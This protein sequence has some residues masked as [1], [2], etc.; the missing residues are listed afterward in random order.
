MTPPRTLFLALLSL[1][2]GVTGCA[3]LTP[4]EQD[5]YDTFDP[6][7]IGE[8]SPNTEDGNVGGGVVTLRGSGFGDDASKVVVQFGDE[9]AEILSINDSEITVVAPTGP[10]TG[11]GV[12]VR[13]ATPSGFVNVENGYAYVIDEMYAN[14]VGYVQVNN[15]WQSC[16]G[17]LSG[18]GYRDDVGCDTF[19]YIGSTGLDGQASALTFAWPRFHSENIGFF[20]GTD[21]SIGDWRF[22]RPGATGFVFGVDELRKDIG[23]VRLVNPFYDT[24]ADVCV[25]LDSTATYRWRGGQE[26]YEAP[27]NVGGVAIPEQSNARDGACPEGTVAYASDVLRFCPTNDVEGVSDLVSR[28]D[29]P[30]AQNFFAAHRRDLKPAEVLLQAPEVGIED[31]PLTLPENLV[32]K[33]EQGFGSLFQGEAPEDYEGDLWG[34]APLLGCFDDDGDGE[35]LDDVA[36]KLTWAP[37]NAELAVGGEVS[38]ARSYVRVTITGLSLNWFGTSGYPVRATLVVPDKYNYDRTTRSSVLEIPASVLYQFP[39]LRPPPNGGQ[40]AVPGDPNRNDWGYLLVTMDRVTDYAVKSDA[41][42]D[43][44]FSYATGDFGFFEW[45]NP[46]DAT[47]CGNCTDDD[48]DGWTD[49]LDPDCLNGGTEETRGRGADACNAGVDNDADGLADSEDP[50]CLSGSDDDEAL[51]AC[52]DGQDEDG[53]GW[54]DASD[55]DCAGGGTRERSLGTAACNDGLDNDA[56][57]LADA[58]D[59]DCSTGADSDEAPPVVG[60]C[61]NGSDDD[62][63]GWADVEDPDCVS[64]DQELG[65]GTGGCNDGVDNDGDGAADRADSDCASPDATELTPPPAVRARRRI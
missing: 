34:V 52:H 41:G 50:D 14:Q 18:D 33:A 17:G 35:R 54:T 5:Y 32:V 58:E 2:L 64:G 31:V 22:E 27:V 15:Y 40:F 45:T 6:P 8:V 24:S 36:L 44:I 1:P 4:A 65:I 60:T 23:E 38:A 39:T 9:N 48:A 56:D 19:A 11:G 63:D 59:P 26:G 61:D 16:L 7:S 30:V 37:S 42:G 55:P 47:G 49:N 43:V 13:V 3:L 62:G 20:G 25:D 21:E 57:G 12:V 51:D 53:D 46:V 29:W 28:V 10:I